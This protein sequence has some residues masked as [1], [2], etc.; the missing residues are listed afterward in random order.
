MRGG[1]ISAVLLLLKAASSD[2]DGGGGATAITEAARGGLLTSFKMSSA[3]RCWRC[4]SAGWN[5][6]MGTALGGAVGGAADVGFSG[7]GC[8]GVPPPPVGGANGLCSRPFEGT[9]F[10]LTRVV[11]FSCSSGKAV[12]GALSEVITTKMLGA[13]STNSSLSSTMSTSVGIVPVAM[14]SP[15]SL[16]K[17]A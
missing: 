14:V 4:C 8:W 1:G 5:A 11:V 6:C 17:T 13:T 12:A 16:F 7:R 3:L 2:D 10:S 15:C 9:A